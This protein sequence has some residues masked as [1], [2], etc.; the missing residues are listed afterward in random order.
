MSKS[1]RSVLKE[2]TTVELL[3][4]KV[5]DTGLVLLSYIKDAVRFDDLF[6]A[7]EELSKKALEVQSGDKVVI[8]IAPDGADADTHP[9]LI[10]CELVK[11]EESAP[12]A[13]DL[14]SDAAASAA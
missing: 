3:N 5:I 9:E 2:P 14:G 1:A 10:N 7:S 12:A 11:K 4:A 13:A 6:N 8:Q